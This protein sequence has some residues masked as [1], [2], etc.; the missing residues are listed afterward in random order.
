MGAR[1]CPESPALAVTMSHRRTRDRDTAKARKFHEDAM[2]AN[3]RKGKSKNGER[4]KCDEA[5]PMIP[6][7]NEDVTKAEPKGPHDLVLQT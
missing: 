5:A 6:K 3:K 2:Q 7:D 1:K 4:G